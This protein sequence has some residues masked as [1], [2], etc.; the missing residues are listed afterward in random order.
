M[1]GSWNP[2][3]SS[4][5]WS[6]ITPFMAMCVSQLHTDSPTPLAEKISILPPSQTHQSRMADTFFP[7]PFFQPELAPSISFLGQLLWTLSLFPKHYTLLSSSWQ[8]NYPSST[9]ITF[10]KKF[11]TFPILWRFTFTMVLWS[12]HNWISQKRCETGSSPIWLAQI[13]YQ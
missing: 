4:A 10:Y 13:C 1:W 6:R 5:L 7:L 8:D 9:C 11:D 2:G 12:R 3:I